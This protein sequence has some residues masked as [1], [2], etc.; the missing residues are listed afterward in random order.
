MV[1][2]GASEAVVFKLLGVVVL[3]YIVYALSAGEVYA[4][5]G[6]WGARSTRAEEPFRYWSTIVVYTILSAALLFVF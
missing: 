2:E 4:K 6:I 1:P 3:L 5:R